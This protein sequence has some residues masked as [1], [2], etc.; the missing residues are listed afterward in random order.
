MFL[1]LSCITQTL[2]M[3]RVIVAR[4]CRIIGIIARNMEESKP[5]RKDIGFYIILHSSLY[6]FCG[7][8][9]FPRS[10]DGLSSSLQKE[11]DHQPGFENLRNCFLCVK[12]EQD[13]CHG[14]ML[15]GVEMSRCVEHNSNLNPSDLCQH[16]VGGA[17][18]TSEQ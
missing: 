3:L 8:V 16:R 13:W 9:C 15:D 14:S 6:V 4:H 10:C 2:A 12:Y 5:K 17:K 18:S 7:F 1:P 11:G